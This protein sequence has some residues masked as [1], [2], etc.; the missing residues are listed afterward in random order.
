MKR[1]HRPPGLSLPEVIDWYMNRGTPDP[2]GCLIAPTP[3][4]NSQYQMI[5]WGGR[6]HSFQSLVVQNR[7]GR[8]LRKGELGRHLCNVKSCINPDHIILGDKTEN[9]VDAVKDRYPQSLVE[10]IRVRYAEG[11]VSYQ[12][13]S[14]EYD[15]PKGTI[16]FWVLRRT[17]VVD[18]VPSD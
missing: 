4:V 13:L 10:E 12:N 8:P 3:N 5:S 1:K 14:D 15:I 7:L 17:R 2:S 9:A 6:P 16:A 11:D 18:D